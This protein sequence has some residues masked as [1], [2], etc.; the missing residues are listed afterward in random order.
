MRFH[1]R[2]N[3]TDAKNLVF[4]QLMDI[5]ENG[6]QFD[7]ARRG[8]ARHPIRNGLSI[9]ERDFYLRVI[10]QSEWNLPSQGIRQKIDDA[11]PDFQL[12]QGRRM[13]GSGHNRQYQE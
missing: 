4:I 5:D 11:N 3:E 7:L 1:S 6:S 13:T 2:S 10:D 8:T 12:V 9:I